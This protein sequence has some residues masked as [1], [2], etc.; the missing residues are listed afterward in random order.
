M[1][2]M[3]QDLKDE[4]TGDLKALLALCLIHGIVHNAGES[5]DYDVK[6]AV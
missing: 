4:K 1:S 3:T 2:Y 5:A 6:H